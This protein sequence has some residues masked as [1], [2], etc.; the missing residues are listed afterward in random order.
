MWCTG[1][2]QQSE[3]EQYLAQRAILEKVVEEAK[4]QADVPNASKNAQKRAIR[5]EKELEVFIEKYQQSK[6]EQK[7]GNDNENNGSDNNVIPTT[8]ADKNNIDQ[9]QQQQS[10]DNN[11]QQKTKR[12]TI[13]HAQLTNIEYMRRLFIL[14][15]TS[16]NLMGIL[17][18][19]FSTLSTTLLP[20]I[21]TFVQLNQYNVNNLEHTHVHIMSQ[22]EAAKLNIILFQP[23]M[24]LQALLT[25]FLILIVYYFY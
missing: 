23:T 7:Q 9:Q 14:H 18:E 15:I 4:K 17:I 16:Q 21:H 5:A 13:P 1:N 11:N 24:Q 12:S 2:V 19:L 10:I 8:T 6:Q 20:L 25:T 22:I 3:E